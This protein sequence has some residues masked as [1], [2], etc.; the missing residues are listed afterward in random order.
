MKSE[1]RIFRGVQSNSYDGLKF[2]KDFVPE[3]SQEKSS[4]NSKDKCEASGS[5]LHLLIVLESW[6]PDRTHFSPCRFLAWL[7]LL[8][9]KME[10][11][12]SPETSVQYY[13]IKRHYLPEASALHGYHHKNKQCNTSL[14]VQP[15]LGCSEGHGK[16]VVKDMGWQKQRTVDQLDIDIEDERK[17]LMLE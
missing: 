4:W 13:F 8:V 5:S 10:T 3:I 15:V 6:S 7:T 1:L 9:M 2:A 11:K 16:D 12:W 17:E 14:L